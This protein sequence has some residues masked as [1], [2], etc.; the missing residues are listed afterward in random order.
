MADVNYTPGK[1]NKRGVWMQLTDQKSNLVR[2]HEKT[3]EENHVWI[4]LK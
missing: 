4:I 2:G 3:I 1:K